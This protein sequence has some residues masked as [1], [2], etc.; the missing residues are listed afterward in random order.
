MLVMSTHIRQN[1]CECWT[2]WPN[3]ELWASLSLSVKPTYKTN[4]KTKQKRNKSHRHKG[5]TNTKIFLFF[6]LGLKVSKSYKF[7]YPNYNIT[8]TCKWKLLFHILMIV[9]K[10]K[11]L[12]FMRKLAQGMQLPFYGIVVLLFHL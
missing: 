9:F 4:T 5:N 3:S 6:P 7:K 11:W 8:C 10:I 1:S 2:V 12:C